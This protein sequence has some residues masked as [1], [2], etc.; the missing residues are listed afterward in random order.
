MPIS[1][2]RNNA[3]P[4]SAALADV[5][6][7]NPPGTRHGSASSR[8]PATPSGWRY[9]MAHGVGATLQ[10]LGKGC[11]RTMSTPRRSSRAGKAVAA[12]RTS[13]SEQQQKAGRGNSAPRSARLAVS[14]PSINNCRRRCA[15]VCQWACGHGGWRFDRRHCWRHLRRPTEE[16]Q[17]Q[18]VSPQDWLGVIHRLWDGARRPPRRADPEAASR[19]GCLQAR[20]DERADQAAKR[21]NERLELMR[22]TEQRQQ[23]RLDKTERSSVS[24]GDHGTRKASLTLR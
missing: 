21:E 13:R 3:T 8:F 24:A 6:A 18:E 20:A 10:S 9:V 22:S 16:E 2:P 15:R 12:C 19:R 4:A 11:S 23:Q 5:S 17:W 1:R 14:P 7:Q